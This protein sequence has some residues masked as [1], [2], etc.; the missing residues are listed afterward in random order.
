MRGTVEP[1]STV[2]VRLSNGAEIT[3][4]AT[5]TGS[6]SVTFA[7]NQLPTGTGSATATFT[8]T[9]PAGNVATLTETFAFDTDAPDALSTLT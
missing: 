9:D 4:T 2:V 8:A 6:W 3:T 1:N 5:S 7:E